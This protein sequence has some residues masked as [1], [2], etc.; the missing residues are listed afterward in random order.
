M[1]TYLEI[2]PTELNKLHN[3]LFS[4]LENVILF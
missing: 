1:E 3:L 2:I 4:K